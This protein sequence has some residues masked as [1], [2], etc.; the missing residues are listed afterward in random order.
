MIVRRAL[1]GWAVAVGVVSEPVAVYE[2][3]E[4][5]R[6]PDAR[7]LDRWRAAFGV[8]PAARACRSPFCGIPPDTSGGGLYLRD[9]CWAPRAVCALTDGNGTLFVGQRDADGRALEARRYIA[10]LGPAAALGAETIETEPTLGGEDFAYFLEKVPGAMTFL[11]I[12]NRT[13]GTDVNLHNAKFQMDESQMP[14]GIVL[15]RARCRPD[16]FWSR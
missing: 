11:G 2:R 7:A 9:R 14:L 15:A 3:C 1:V 6:S 13:L 10:V 16:L 5:P 12:G 8:H 4:T